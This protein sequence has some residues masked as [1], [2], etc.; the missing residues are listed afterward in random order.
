MI[1]SIFLNVPI[2]R[3]KSHV[4]LQYPFPPLVE[5]HSGHSPATRIPNPTCSTSP[6]LARVSKIVNN[7]FIDCH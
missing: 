5:K 1:F 4:S 6:G 7:S 2:S 3:T